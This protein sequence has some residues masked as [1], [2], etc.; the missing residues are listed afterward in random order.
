MAARSAEPGRPAKKKT[1]QFAA[2]GG[3]TDGLKEVNACDVTRPG[4]ARPNERAA[5]RSDIPSGK[6]GLPP[7]KSA[8][9]SCPYSARQCAGH[10]GLRRMRNLRRRRHGIRSA[11]TPHSASN[12]QPVLGQCRRVKPWGREKVVRR[13]GNYPG[14]GAHLVCI[15]SMLCTLKYKIENLGEIWSYKS[16]L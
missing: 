6:A 10:L 11:I 1:L 13:T 5:N 3:N 7:A 14:C 15:G 12:C 9:V 2:L 4:N 8:E 16:K